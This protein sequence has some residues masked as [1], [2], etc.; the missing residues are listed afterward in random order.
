MGKDD[1]K[2][3]SVQGLEKG[4]GPRNHLSPAGHTVILPSVHWLSEW[5]LPSYCGEKQ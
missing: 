5:D 2:Q 1:Y 4:P 3:I